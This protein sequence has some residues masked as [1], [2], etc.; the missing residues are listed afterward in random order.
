MLYYGADST[1]GAAGAP[2]PNAAARNTVLFKA[3]G[4]AYIPQTAAPLDFITTDGNDFQ[5]VVD[6]TAVVAA[7]GPGTYSVADVQAGTGRDRQAGWALAVAYRDTAQPPR[8]LTIFDGFQ[9]VNGGNPNVRTGPVSGFQTP[10]TG[11]V[12]T[13][14]G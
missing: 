10:P 9:I 3:P 5:G 6:V 14:L 8:N 12:R 13:R 7:A 4:G 2:P 11:P 1:A